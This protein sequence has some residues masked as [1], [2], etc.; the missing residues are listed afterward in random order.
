[1]R[2]LIGMVGTLVRRL[3][4]LAVLGLLLVGMLVWAVAAPARAACTC[5]D[6]TTQEHADGA[7]AVFSGTVRETRKPASDDGGR[8]KGEV[9]YV[10]DVEQVWKEDGT[11]V[12]DTVRVTSPRAESACGLGDLPPG[13]DYVF[14]AKAR[15]TGFRAAA[16]GGSSGLTDAFEAEVVAVLGEGRAVVPDS[17]TPVVELTPVDDSPPRSVTRVAAPGAAL[18]IVGLLGLVLVRVAGS[19]RS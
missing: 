18:A 4:A 9:T 5:Q 17:E 15:D 8:A 11:V 2:R 13:T 7:D 12:T 19:R 14:F 6:Q 10:V 1:M 3:G 16:C